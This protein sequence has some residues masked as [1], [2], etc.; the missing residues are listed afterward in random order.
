MPDKTIRKGRLHST[1]YDQNS[2][3]VVE[4]AGKDTRDSVVKTAARCCPEKKSCSKSETSSAHRQR[5]S[6]RS[7]QTSAAAAT[8]EVA[9]GR[10][11][12]QAEG[13]HDIDNRPAAKQRY[14]SASWIHPYFRRCDRPAMIGEGAR[15]RFRRCNRIL[16]FVSRTEHKLQ[17]KAR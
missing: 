13:H 15:M 17:L 14:S 3:A 12:L 2:R 11:L 16:N 8:A 5:R 4:N 9:V 1:Y 10:A 7:S 6:P